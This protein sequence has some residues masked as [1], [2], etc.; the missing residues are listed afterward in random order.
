MKCFT[1]QLLFV[2]SAAIFVLFLFSPDTVQRTAYESVLFCSAVLIPSLFP[3]FVLSDVLISLSSGA[4]HRSGGLFFQVF[5]LPPALIRCWL[6]GLLA[7]FPT[8]ADCA[9]RMVRAGEIEKND[10]ERCLAFTNN[11]G[12][13]F[14][15]CAVG[16]GIFGSMFIGLYL[17]VIQTVAATLVGDVMA[18]PN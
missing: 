7:G 16:S 13:V 1:V 6:I 9:V 15:I 5:R 17:W 8:A 4:K 12:I 3:G 10:G 11:P 14:V 2:F 18:N